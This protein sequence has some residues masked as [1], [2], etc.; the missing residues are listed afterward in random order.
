MTF[1]PSPDRMNPALEKLTKYLRLEA[2]RNFDNRA[3]L[4]GLERMLEPWEAEAHA[5]GLPDALTRAVVTRLRD[6]PRLTASS[7]QEVLRGLWARLRAEF[8]DLLR[9]PGPEASQAAATPPAPS[10]PAAA[11]PAAAAAAQAPSS[12]PTPERAPIAAVRA[13][14]PDPREP[15]EER[16]APSAADGEPDREPEAEA[17]ID[18]PDE[19]GPPAPA[20][21]GP[22]PGYDAPLTIVQG[23]GPKSAGN[24]ERL[25][26]RTL[27]DLLWHLPRRYD[28]YSQ[29]KT[30][31][32][33]W[34]GEEVTVIA[35]VEEIHVRPVRGGKMKLIEA[36][37][38][39]GTGAL[40]A[41]WFNQPWIAEQ[42]RPGHPVVLA[43]KVEQY[44]G[45]L[46]LN[47]P[48]YEA[49]E[50]QQLHTNRIVP[51]YPLTA[52]VT[53]KWLRRV[54]S[55]VVAR[56]APRLPDPLPESVRRSAGVMPLGQALQQVHFPDG[57]EHLRR[58]QD[59]LAFEEMLLLQLG[60][61]RQRGEWESLTAEPF[62]IEDS[63]LEAF[64]AG[65]PYALTAAQQRALG[66]L[67]ADLAGTRPMNRLLQGDVGSGKTVLA[68][69][70]LAIV[71]GH[72]A[73][74]AVLAP[75]SIL[76]EQHLNTLRALLAGAGLEPESI[77]LLIGATPEAEKAE[78]RRGLQEGGVR[79]V[80]GTHALLEDPVSF[81]RLGLAVIDEQ[82]RFGVEQRAALR[83]KGRNPHLLVMTATPIP[84]S[85]ALTLYGDLDL[86]LLDE[87]PPGRQPIETRLMLPVERSRA[88]AF[89]RSQVEAGRQAY[90]IYPLVEGSEKVEAK[91]AV[92]EYERL[93]KE[94]F[95]G[96]RLGLLHGRMRPDEKESVMAAFREGTTPIL[97][98]TAVVEVGVDVPNATVMLI[99]G[100]NRFGLSQLHQFRGRVGRGPHASYCLLIPDREDEAENE[101][102]KALE[103]TQ[104]GFRLAELDLELRGPGDFLGTRQSGFA[105]L[106]TA[107]LTDVR[108]IEKARREAQRLFADDP[109]LARPEHRLLA[110]A[111][112]R[113]WSG[114]KG[115]IS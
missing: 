101:R 85:L 60:V 32:R 17:P 3:V 12:E 89:I 84:R 104:D 28:D 65:L 42:L 19:A 103:S 93:Q 82:H 40:R 15:E 18:E 20:P 98:S 70:A 57:W 87:M 21:D 102:L 75:T 1:E 37:V 69:A 109:A 71:S 6:Y 110:E 47:N 56:M 114:T 30:I 67:R 29:L 112:D 50:R 26:L 16:V 13:A 106:R 25:G 80:V 73:Q 10:A 63:G 66:D 54:I 48:E 96:L 14:P 33:L 113:F 22:P 4:G 44:L 27:G 7:R 5:S 38:S 68:A 58:A 35:T 52:G 9:P 41:T 8:P 111:V 83:S 11:P 43:G 2:E 99:E 92:D 36:V 64:I 97:V 77:R 74:A 51:V 61:L 100:A 34:Y 81:A 72:Q 79:V 90:L 55:S 91:A 62:P 24:L 108:L 59:R 88:Q 39:D 23:I 46:T 95:P 94:V 31:S 78:I 86:T 49:V 107:R 105:E 45:R 53:G 76:A 115:E